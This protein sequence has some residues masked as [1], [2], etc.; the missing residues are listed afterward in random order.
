MSSMPWT[1][2]MMMSVMTTSAG[3]CANV[4]TASTPLVIT[5]TW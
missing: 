4:A 3:D 1:F 5:V 2:G